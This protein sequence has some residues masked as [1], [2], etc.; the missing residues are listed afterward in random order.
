LIAAALLLAAACIPP[1]G[2]PTPVLTWDLL[3]ASSNVLG[4]SLWYRFPGGTFQ[5]IVDFPC[6]NHLEDGVLIE[7]IC[8]GGNL[9][10]PVQRHRTDEGIEVEFCVDAWNTFGRSPSCSNVIRVCMPQVWQSGEVYQ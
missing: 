7:K 9:G 6:V 5:K 10:D 8:R 2:F 4:Y 1:P 3:P